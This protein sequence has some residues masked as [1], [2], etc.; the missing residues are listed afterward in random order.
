MDYPN[1]VNAELRKSLVLSLIHWE[2]L[3]A[4]AVKQL[5]VNKGLKLDCIALIAFSRLSNNDYNKPL[6]V[7][8]ALCTYCSQICTIC[9]LAEEMGVSCSCA[10]SLYCQAV[11]SESW[12]EFIKY[13]S[14]LIYTLKGL[15]AKYD[16]GEVEEA[17]V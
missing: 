12:P 16:R 17:Y 10:N 7:S 13:A 2:N 6:A 15:V 5:A 14:M 11:R 1:V 8:C 4:I 9:P 3:R